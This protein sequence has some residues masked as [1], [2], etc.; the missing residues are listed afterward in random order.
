MFLDPPYAKE[1][2]RDMGCY[3]KF[4]DGDV[5]H[6]VRKWCIENENNRRLRI[7][8]C[9]YIGDGNDELAEHGWTAFR[10][11]ANGGYSGYS[12]REQSKMNRSREVIWFSPSCLDGVSGGML[13]Q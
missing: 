12:Q 13:F 2:D 4:D 5:A 6:R 9:A 3:G 11:K 1:A 8:L 10:W 7:A